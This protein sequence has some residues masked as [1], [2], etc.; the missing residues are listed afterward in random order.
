M[1]SGSTEKSPIV[2][3]IEGIVAVVL[4]VQIGRSCA[5]SW[6]LNS[7]QEIYSLGHS[8]S[9]RPLATLLF[10]NADSAP[11][12]E[13]QL[14]MSASETLTA[15]GVRHSTTPTNFIHYHDNSVDRAT[16]PYHRSWTLFQFAWLA[17]RW[18]QGLITQTV[19]KSLDHGADAGPAPAVTSHGSG[20]CRQWTVFA[21][22]YSLSSSFSRF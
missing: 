20:R 9:Y 16:P 22:S 11:N 13:K 4:R 17:L 2:F 3:G 7:R 10:F 15:T 12:T 1:L 19:A 8:L 18:H 5:E 6:L 21:P 14:C